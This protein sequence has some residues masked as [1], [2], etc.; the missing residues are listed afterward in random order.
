MFAK[1]DLSFQ[2]IVNY[3]TIHPFLFLQLLLPINHF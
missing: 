3:D 2:K 1:S